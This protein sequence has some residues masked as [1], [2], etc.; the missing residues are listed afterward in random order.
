[1]KSLILMML[2]AF[3]M[4]CSPA[5]AETMAKWPKEVPQVEKKEMATDVLADGVESLE[6]EV[7]EALGMAEEPA[8]EITEEADEFEKSSAGMSEDGPRVL[9]AQALGELKV[10]AERD[11]EIARVKEYEA[12]L[13]ELKRAEVCLQRLGV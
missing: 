12:A 7:G 5:F 9:I 11:P 10:M 2:A 8:Q 6:S 13:R 1:M 3:A 4:C